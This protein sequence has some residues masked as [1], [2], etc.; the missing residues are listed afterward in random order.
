MLSFAF[1]CR[2]CFFFIKMPFS[3]P[4][5]FS[6]LFTSHPL[7]EG[8]SDK[9]AWWA[10]GIQSRSS[11]HSVQPE[12]FKG[13]KIKHS[14]SLIILLPLYFCLCFC[15]S[16][17]FNAS[18]CKIVIFYFPWY[19]PNYIFRSLIM[20]CYLLKT[21]GYIIQGIHGLCK[22]KVLLPLYLRDF[23]TE[24][25]FWNYHSRWPW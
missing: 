23:L 3:N 20:S 11:H 24:S 5:V 17:F 10:P 1:V 16:H 22:I 19:T 15:H 8:K 9:R 2:F 12:K 4:W 13:K 14:V 18:G 25:Q 7:A 6:V 21:T